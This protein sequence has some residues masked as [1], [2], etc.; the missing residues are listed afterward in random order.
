MCCKFKISFTIHQI[1]HPF[2]SFNVKC[3]INY[4]KNW[5]S[6]V[7]AGTNPIKLMEWFPHFGIWSYC[8]LSLMVLHLLPCFGLD[9]PPAPPSAWWCWA[10]PER[11]GSATSS[12][13]SSP[14]CWARRQSS[15]MAPSCW[16]SARTFIRLSSCFRP[17]SF[18][19]LPRGQSQS[20]ASQVA[21]ST[22]MFHPGVRFRY[23][24]FRHVHCVEAQ[25]RP[26]YSKAIRWSYWA[27]CTVVGG[28][29]LSQPRRPAQCLLLWSQ[30]LFGSRPTL[31]GPPP[32]ST[33]ALI[34]CHR[35]SAHRIRERRR[36]G[37]N[38]SFSTP[39]AIY[40]FH[41]SVVL[42]TGMLTLHPIHT[43]L[44]HHDRRPAAP[45]FSG[46]ITDTFSSRSHVQ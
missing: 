7:H 40:H 9:I 24:L 30:L 38:N 39:M 26:K 28:Y 12:W 29:L 18:Y 13:W 37:S 31:V 43:P 17:F 21:R 44:P 25:V 33:R 35:L 4:F 10:P 1:K 27:R 45:A 22:M 46:E 16:H 19:T 8:T 15:T 20:D 34:K 6:N 14:W 32:A 23:L 41:H 2:F 42:S 36:G 11:G 5:L 3:N